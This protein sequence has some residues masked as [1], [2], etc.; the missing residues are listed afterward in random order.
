M[1]VRKIALMH[2][3]YGYSDGEC[4]ECSNFQRIVHRDRRYSKC[5]VYGNTSSSASDWS[6]KYHACGMMNQEYKGKPTICMVR[7]DQK[8]TEEVEG[9]ISFL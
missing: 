7:K 9:Q 3:M 2:L 1:A 6:G 8:S 4:R 5:S